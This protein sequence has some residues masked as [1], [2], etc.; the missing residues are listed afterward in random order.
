MSAALWTFVA[1]EDLSFSKVMT[2]AVVASDFMTIVDWW[3]MNVN[4][5][6]IIINC[7]F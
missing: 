1:W 7:S 4:I 3:Y 2:F 5:I 6:I